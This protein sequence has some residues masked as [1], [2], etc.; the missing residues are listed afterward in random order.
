MRALLVLLC[1]AGTA[2][3]DATADVTKAFD[4]FVDSVAAKKT[5]PASAGVE[6]FM[7]PDAQYMDQPPIPDSFEGIEGMLDKPKVTIVQVELSPSGRSAWVAAEVSAHVARRDKKT[8]VNEALRV[9][10]FFALDAKAGWQLK[11]TA[12]S[13]AEPNQPLEGMGCGMAKDEWH[14]ETKITKAA[15]PVVKALWGGFGYEDKGGVV[16]VM[17]DDKKAVLFGS[18]AGEKLTG[19]AAIKKIF[20]KWGNLH[21]QGDNIETPSAFAGIGPDGELAWVGTAVWAQDKFCTIYRTFFVL[22]KEAGGWKVVHQHY[23]ERY[24][25]F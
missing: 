22:A 16:S 12:W 7:I 5:K 21:M 6:L 10:A 13:T 2:Y 19:G 18:A 14:I 1:F 15:L 17:S 4:A 8:P 24:R 9:S 3:A 25:G 20:K 23:A 11:A